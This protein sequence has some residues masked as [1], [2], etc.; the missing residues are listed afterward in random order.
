MDY[1]SWK[2]QYPP[3]WD[4]EDDNECSFCGV[5]IPDGD[6]YCSKDCKRADYAENTYNT[7]TLG[8]L[9]KG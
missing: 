5:P 4:Y 6:T 9:D 1:D 7:P 8:S 2:T 3:E